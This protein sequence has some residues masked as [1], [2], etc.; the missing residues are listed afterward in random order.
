MFF[1]IPVSYRLY[2]LIP[3]FSHSTFRS[4]L[5]QDSCESSP[6]GSLHRL[7]CALSSTYPAPC[8][9]L[10]AHSH[11]FIQKIFAELHLSTTCH[12]LCQGL[13]VQGLF[14]LTA[15]LQQGYRLPNKHSKKCLITVV[16][17][18][19]KDSG[20]TYMYK[21]KPNLIWEDQGESFPLKRHLNRNWKTGKTNQAKNC[22]RAS[23]AEGTTC[24]KAFR[25]H[26]RNC[27]DN[28]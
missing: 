6:T 2:A 20:C 26:S 27:E 11:S 22:W 3:P 4:Q 5:K 28:Q 13:G 8:P 7:I 24:A 17:S 1:Y 21:Q 19:I 15:I 10:C 18:V 16:L 25:Q 14:S 12:T 23:Q 9:W